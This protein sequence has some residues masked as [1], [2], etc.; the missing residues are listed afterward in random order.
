MSHFQHAN[1][2]FLLQGKRGSG[3]ASQTNQ[4]ASSGFAFV[5][6]EHFMTTEKTFNTVWSGLDLESTSGHLNF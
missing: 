5:H 6:C 1:L 3:Q 4:T 2:H